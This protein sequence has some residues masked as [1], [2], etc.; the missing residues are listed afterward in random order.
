MSV[1][2]VVLNE[3]TPAGSDK[4]REGDDRIR[5]YKTQNREIVGVDHK[6]ESSGQDA[7]MG[8][9]N[10]ISFLEQADI[11][12]GAEGK[13]LFGAQTVNGKPELVFTDED[14]NDHLVVAPAG[15]V[16]M[17]AGAI[18]SIPMGYLACDG[19]A[20]SRTT[21]AVLFAAISTIHGV[22]NGSTTFN[23]PDFRDK[24][25]IGAKQDD[26]GVP[27][28]N[29]TGSLTASGGAATHTLTTDEIPSHTH[30]VSKATQW[31]AS[32]T[33]F[34]GYSSGSPTAG[35]GTGGGSAHNNLPPYY[36]MLFM[37]KI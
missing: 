4:M 17:F 28:T 2:T 6:Y 13:P 21:Y 31:G 35:S 15:S 12:V 5:E 27:K 29:V 24:F 36:A 14:D 9:H 16:L 18:A 7:D 22:G 8:K 11:G 34:A 10:Q 30:T 3:A 26:S 33:H 1:P 19:S 23:L 32:G 37:I 25:I 20:V